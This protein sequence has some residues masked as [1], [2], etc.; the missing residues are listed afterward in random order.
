MADVYCRTPCH[1]N[2]CG[3][4]GFYGVRRIRRELHLR[5]MLKENIHVEIPALDIKAPILEGI[6]QEVLRQ[7]TGH[8][9]NTGEPGSGNYCIAGHSSVIYKEFFNNLKKIPL[10]TEILL[11][12]MQEN[13]YCYEMKESFIVE[14]DEIWILEDF[15]DD[16]ITIITCTVDGTQRLVV[17]GILY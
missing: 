5:R 9:E 8:F 7:A 10:G 1:N 17:V 16:R 6:G 13:C 4:L 11:Y 3:S 14:P 15:M 2:R 12:D